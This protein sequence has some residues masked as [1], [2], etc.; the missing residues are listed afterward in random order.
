M[1]RFSK[2]T[3]DKLIKLA[4]LCP[5]LIE[6][7][8][9]L[10]KENLYRHSLKKTGNTFIKEL[11]KHMD[12]IWSRMSDENKVKNTERIAHVSSCFDESVALIL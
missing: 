11:D 4:T 1:S 3:Q 8:E 7:L 10:E 6:L 5:I 2:E 12:D 9:D